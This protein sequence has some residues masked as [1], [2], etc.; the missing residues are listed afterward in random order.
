MK[1]QQLLR[2]N[3]ITYPVM[4]VL[5]LYQALMMVLGIVGILGLTWRVGTQL[6]TSLLGCVVCSFFFFTKKDQLSGGIGMMVSAICVVAVSRLIGT[7][8]DT[9]VYSIPILVVAMVYMN[10]KLMIWLNVVCLASNIIA[11]ILNI[12]HLMESSGTT[13]FISVLFSIIIA[14]TSIIVTNLLIK[15]NKEN[16]DAVADTAVQQENSNKMMSAV[17]DDISKNFED[18]MQML[19]TLQTSLDNS[20][21]SMKNIA[22]STEMTAESIQ[23][24]AAMCTEIGGA[25]DKAEKVSG[26]MLEASNRVGNTIATIEKDMQELKVQAESV[27]S[28]SRITV[29]V[30]EELTRK[31]SEVEN[32]VGTILSISSQTNL[33]ALNASI[34][35]ARAGTAGKGFAV[36]ADEIRILSEQTKEASNNITNII[37][38]LMDGTQKANESIT[39]S[40]QSVTSQNELIMKARKRF[41]QVVEEMNDLNA[42]IQSTENSMKE[43]IEYSGVISDNISQLSATSEEVAA[44]SNESLNY[45]NVTVTEVAKCREVFETIYEL[46]QQLKNAN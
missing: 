26:E 34:E 39:N 20:S 6:V 13:M 27:E 9:W 46:A 1:N 25:T 11:F 2:A 21:F 14:F 24:Q 33:L 23:T 3:K 41:E 32:F 38:E 22:D 17:A 31:V 37:Q 8:M 42:G 5:M 44:S 18:A 45:S 40:V 4:M 15:F 35:A 29:D 7:Q 19:N 10:K 36:V 12:S 28:A 43:I 16:L 30:V